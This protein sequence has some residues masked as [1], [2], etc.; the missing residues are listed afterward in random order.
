MFS[1]CQLTHS[2]LTQTNNSY[3]S[4]PSAEDIQGLNSFLNDLKSKADQ[5][6]AMASWEFGEML[7]NGILTDSQKLTLQQQYGVENVEL[8]S[9]NQDID[10]SIRFLKV[11]SDAKV[12]EAMADLASCMLYGQGV[13]ADPK[14]ALKLAEESS[15]L[16]SR[17]GTSIL[18]VYYKFYSKD[19]N[20][21]SKAVKYA[22]ESAEIATSKYILGQA[23]FDGKYL[24][25]SQSK[26]LALMTEAAQDKLY[27]AYLFLASY[28]VKMNNAQDSLYYASKA[29]EQNPEHPDSCLAYGAAL[30]LNPVQD[31]S[32]R[33][34]TVVNKLNEML[35]TGNLK[36]AEPAQ[37]I[38]AV[39]A[40][41]NRLNMNFSN[42]FKIMQMGKERG[43]ASAKTWFKDFNKNFADNKRKAKKGDAEAMIKLMN[44]YFVCDENGN[45]NPVKGIEYARK[46]ESIG[47]P[48]GYFALANLYFAGQYLPQDKN[49][50]LAYLNA[51]AQKGYQPA[52]KLMNEYIAHNNA[53]QAQKAA[54]QAAQEQQLYEAKMRLIQEQRQAIQDQE[55]DRRMQQN[56]VR[57][58][59]CLLNPSSAFCTTF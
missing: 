10:T 12:P 13:E 2:S 3:Q 23:Y 37:N 42:V 55:F 17:F 32:P 50:G 44:M 5:G 14:Q 22:Q 54:Q 25:Q 26:G 47:H 11:A 9:I 59:N 53:L 51:A 20:A 36:Y 16:G 21:E 40:S 41:N 19:K 39:L 43:I 38:L 30:I 27:M 49:A 35:T 58:T 31:V 24:P 7:L 46:L 1:G 4:T 57:F 18:A 6:D 45:P 33:A 15:K 52:V 29:F 34:S 28:S 48:E 8:L 56:R